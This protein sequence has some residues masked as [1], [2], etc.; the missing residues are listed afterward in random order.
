MQYSQLA[1]KMKATT[2]NDAQGTIKNVGDMF[3]P[4]SFGC[5]QSFLK[6]V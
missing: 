3:E 1:I 4:V 6:R 2:L 5:S